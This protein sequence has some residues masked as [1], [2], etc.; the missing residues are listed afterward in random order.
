[1]QWEV[2]SRNVQPSQSISDSQSEREPRRSRRNLRA[3]VRISIVLTKHHDHKR[4]KKERVCASL[5]FSGHTPPVTQTRA[6]TDGRNWGRG[7]G[8][9]LLTDL[10][11][12]ACSICFLIQHGAQN[13]GWQC[14]QWTGPSLI[15]CQ[16]R[17]ML[18]SL[19]RASVRWGHFHNWVL[20]FSN[21]SSLCRVCRKLASLVTKESYHRMWSAFSVSHA[22]SMCMQGCSSW[23]LCS[24]GL[25]KIILAT[26]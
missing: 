3:I 2:Y 22:D 1:M 19:L 25:K 12:L 21:D 6:G 7:H 5:Q 8:G 11:L 4:L 26:A 20:F 23:I 16:S 15:S 10:L 14:P 18:H 17:K 9:G 13:Q 24:F